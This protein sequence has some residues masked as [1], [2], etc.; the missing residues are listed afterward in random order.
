[1]RK[2]ILLL[3]VMTL[4]FTG[5]TPK[6]ETSDK[7]TIVTTMFPAYDFA[8]QI[9]GDKA[10]IILLVPAGTESHSYEPT[11][12]D[13]IKIQ[14]SDLFICNGGESEHWVEELTNETT[15]NSMLKMTSFVKALP[16]E[17]GHDEHVWC[18]PLNAVSI[19]QAIY[20]ELC[21]LDTENTE[22][23]TENYKLFKEQLL[24]LHDTFKEIVE[25]AENKTVVFADRFP[26][27]YF[28]EE[29][30][31]SH[32]SAYS[33]CSTEAEPSASLIAQLANKV[34]TENIK[35]VFY[36]EFSNEKIADIICEETGCEK[37]LFHSCHTVSKNDI[38][39]GE[40]YISI[41]TKNAENLRKVLN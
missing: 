30:G 27:R 14:N 41:M 26:V 24:N 18:S 38:E 40:T 39:H 21:N 19:S 9:A 22:F 1:M 33:G 7:L 13:M 34:K 29:Y 32:F 4:I 17:E 23:Y 31:L 16:E 28:T 2:I 6:A 15:L 5:C 37:Y 35:G 25:N 12:K 8:R 11:P 10:E 20:E 36:I 3:L